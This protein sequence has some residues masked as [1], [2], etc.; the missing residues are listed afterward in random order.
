MKW[1]PSQN[2]T[3]S[4]VLKCWNSCI[5]CVRMYICFKPQPN[6]NNFTMIGRQTF[7]RCASLRPYVAQWKRLIGDEHENYMWKEHQILTWKLLP[8]SIVCTLIDLSSSQQSLLTRSKKNWILFDAVIFFGSSVSV[9]FFCLSSFLVSSVSMYRLYAVFSFTGT[10]VV[11]SFW[12]VLSV[13]CNS[14]YIGSYAEFSNNSIF[15]SGG[16]FK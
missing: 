9:G 12:W 4:C 10:I 1:K 14:N 11:S 5:F 2:W 7:D 3:L 13:L 8:P 15:F 6:N 16:L